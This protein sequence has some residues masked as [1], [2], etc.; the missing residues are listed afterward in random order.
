MIDDARGGCV[1]VVD[2]D[3]SVRDAL[4]EVV[5]MGGCSVIVAANG[6]EALKLLQGR[7]PC[8]IILDLMMPVM[9]GTE[10]LEALKL[11]PALASVP[12]VISTS[13]PDRAPRGVPLIAKPIDINAVWAWMRQ[14]CSCAEGHSISVL[15]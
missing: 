6:A 15:P 5:E 7:R 14:S 2:D 9:S 13:A 8:L 4:T 11:D 3:E 12:V 1:L 10:V